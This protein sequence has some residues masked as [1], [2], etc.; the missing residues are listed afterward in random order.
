MLEDLKTSKG[1]DLKAACRT[2]NLEWRRVKWF[3]AL[4]VVLG[5]SYA[6]PLYELAT[7]A[8]SSDLYSHIL[9]VPFISA[10]AAWLRRADL[11]SPHPSRAIGALSFIIGALFLG[12]YAREVQKPVMAG[13]ADV[14]CP[15]VLSFLGFLYSIVAATLGWRTFRR[16][17]FPLLFLLFGVPFP[18]AC[19][20]G[21]EMVLQQGSAMVAHCFFGLT[22]TPA[23]RDGLAFQLPGVSIQVAPECSGIHSTLVLFITSIVAAQFFLKNPPSRAALVLAIVPLAF[24]RNGFRIFTIGELCVH[25]GPQMLDHWIHR[26]GGPVFFALSLIPLFLWLLFLV[27][28]ERKNRTEAEGRRGN[29][30]TGGRTERQ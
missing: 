2:E 22:G 12:L 16:F 6:K 21:I 9:L 18:S 13:T 29:R 28:W 23:L 10:Y 20:R 3:A 25:Y 15:L 17:Q 5:I 19:L 27:R 4:S 26:R 1:G 7:F 11:V 24:L 14:Y 30:Q 8:W